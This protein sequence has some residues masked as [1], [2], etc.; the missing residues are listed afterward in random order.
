MDLRPSFGHQEFLET[1]SQNSATSNRPNESPT[2]SVNRV[3]RYPQH[4]PVSQFMQQSSSTGSLSHV[5]EAYRRL[6]LRLSA[7]AHGN[8]KQAKSTNRMAQLR[9]GPYSG[10][11]PYVLFEGDPVE[12]GTSNSPR[13]EIRMARTPKVPR[14]DYADHGDHGNGT[15]VQSKSLLRVLTFQAKEQ[16]RKWQDAE[17]PHDKSAVPQIEHSSEHTNSPH[18][19]A[20]LSQLHLKT[21]QS[22]GGRLAPLDEQDAMIDW[23][24]QRHFRHG[25]SH[26]ARQAMGP[27]MVNNNVGKGFLSAVLEIHSDTSVS[28]VG[29]YSERSTRTS[30]SQ[31]VATRTSQVT[32]SP[33]RDAASLSL[34]S[35]RMP[36]PPPQRGKCLTSPAAGVAN[37]GLDNGE[38]NLIVF[39]NDSILVAKKSEHS[40]GE[41][42]EAPGSSRM[43]EY[44][45]LS[46][47]GQGT[48]AQ[49]FKCLHVPSGRLVAVKIVKNKPSYTRQA[50]VEI[51]IFRALQEQDGVQSSSASQ[52]SRSS[53]APTRDYMV[54]L[55]CF[56]MYRSHLCL[57]FD[58]LGLNLYEVLKRRQFRGLPLTT[59]RSIIRQVMVGL[60]SLSSKNIVHCDLKP[61][62]L[63]LVSDDAIQQIVNTGE[64]RRATSGKTLNE[65]T[66]HKATGSSSRSPNVPTATVAGSDTS[67]RTIKL[68]DFGSACFEGYTAHTY[69]QSRFYRSPE[70][71]IGLPYDSAIDMWSLGCVAAELFLG[72]PILPGV[73][74]HDQL[75]RIG[76]MIGKMPDWMLVRFGFLR[77]HPV[78]GRG[79]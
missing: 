21:P 62:N 13:Q 41:E 72:L 45:V 42:K 60:R 32:S 7:L 4:H 24:R 2:N 71:L 66:D 70:V 52:I 25:D 27:P 30:P 59:V 50:A 16:F 3:Q 47:L 48:F 74:E 46:L 5:D 61:E 53:A 6:G 44:R 38:G 65:N 33:T 36:D 29:G 9:P 35:G 69:I 76:E 31:S 68:I 54:N 58:L 34:G 49:V 75:G 77:T 43:V 11:T 56:F 8:A 26:D 17:P 73:H 14:T 51:D 67:S 40:L 18:Q 63:L 10:F 28:G 20:S 79:F 22:D 23:N 55:I 12:N 1:L 78:T 37:D 15:R 64:P 57:V 39:E 19:Y